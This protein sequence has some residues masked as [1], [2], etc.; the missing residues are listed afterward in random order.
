MS[1]FRAPLWVAHSPPPPQNTRLADPGMEPEQGSCATAG[2]PWVA[3]GPSRDVFW[4]ARAVLSPRRKH[5]CSYLQPVLT[6]RLPTHWL[7]EGVT[8]KAAAPTC[9]HRA[10]VGPGSEHPR[11]GCFSELT[12]TE[13]HREL[14]LTLPEKKNAKVG[15]YCKTP[16]WL[17]LGLEA[18]KL[19]VVLTSYLLSVTPNRK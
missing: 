1:A 18:I 4:T 19:Q 17:P 13:P 11:H 12:A 15:Q 6:S 2:S 5:N 3:S 14:D 9:L 16:P 10:W 8:D 7:Q